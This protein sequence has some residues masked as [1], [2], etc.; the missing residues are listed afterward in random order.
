MAAQFLRTPGLISS[1]PITLVVSSIDKASSSYIMV[2]D[3]YVA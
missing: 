1:G 2:D 3:M